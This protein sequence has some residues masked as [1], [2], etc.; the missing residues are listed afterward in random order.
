MQLAELQEYASRRGWEVAG[1]YIDE[2]VSG[3]KQSSPA[4]NPSW[5]TLTGGGSQPCSSGRSI[6]LV[7]H[8]GTL[9]THCRPRRHGHRVRES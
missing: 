5:L 9:S 1:E 6:A 3:A 4:M 8:C 7:G 2:G